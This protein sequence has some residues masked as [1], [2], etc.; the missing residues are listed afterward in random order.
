MQSKYYFQTRNG[1]K[2]KVRKGLKRKV[3][4]DIEIGV[5]SA[6]TSGGF[7][8]GTGAGVALA[9]SI[10]KS[11]ALKTV[12]MSLGAVGGSV[13]ATILANRA[14]EKKAGLTESDGT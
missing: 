11:P 13:V 14:L 12:F 2:V 4:R 9:R 1:K 10:N 3:K 5:K 6:A 7:V 8:A